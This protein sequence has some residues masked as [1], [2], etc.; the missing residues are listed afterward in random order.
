MRDLPGMGHKIT[1]YVATFPA[2]SHGVLGRLEV[3]LFC[4]E[5]IMPGKQKRKAT[6]GK[7]KL[8]DCLWED[9]SSQL[10]SKNISFNS[11]E[12]EKQRRTK[13]QTTNAW[14]AT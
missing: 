14:K 9:E 4:V 2:A 7:S 11:K 5:S 10:V 12:C 8:I 3:S 13:L 1:K 6:R